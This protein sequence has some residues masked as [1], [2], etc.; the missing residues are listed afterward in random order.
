MV[1]LPPLNP[2]QQKEKDKI[3]KELN[4]G[5]C[6]PEMSLSNA[7]GDRVGYSR[8][9]D[10][11]H[12]IDQNSQ[13]DVKADYFKKGNTEKADY[14]TISASGTD[15]ICISPITVTFP[16]SSDTY[17]FLPGEVAAVCNNHKPEYNYYWSESATSVHF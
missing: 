3:Y 12:V 5:G 1:G 14:I 11:K 7:N 17:A 8:N 6:A 16:A 2:E 10:C 4:Y 13:T 15:A 9:W